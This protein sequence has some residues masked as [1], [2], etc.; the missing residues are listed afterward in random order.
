MILVNYTLR[1]NFAKIFVLH[2]VILRRHEWS[3]RRLRDWSRILKRNSRSYVPTW[4][5]WCLLSHVE[6]TKWFIRTFSRANG[7]E[8]SR[9]S[10]VNASLIY[11]QLL[12]CGSALITLGHRDGRRL[13]YYYLPRHH[14]SRIAVKIYR[15]L[16]SPPPSATVSACERMERRN[17]PWLECS[18]RLLFFSFRLKINVPITECAQ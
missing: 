2:I 4:Y 18:V 12:P 7:K 13:R 10:S 9:C 8:S 14:V 15:I 16:L 5:S 6:G 11:G 17:R 1:K 3:Y